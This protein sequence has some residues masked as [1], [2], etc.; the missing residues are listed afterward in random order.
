MVCLLVAIPTCPRPA[1]SPT[2][3]LLRLLIPAFSPLPVIALGSLPLL[4]SFRGP[5][6]CPPSNVVHLVLLLEWELSFH[7]F[8]HVV[9]FDTFLKICTRFVLEFNVFSLQSS[10]SVIM[11]QN[12]INVNSWTMVFSS[13]AGSFSLSNLLAVSATR[14]PSSASRFMNF[15]F[16]LNVG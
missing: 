1:S 15:T 6:R 3:H 14:S 8:G 7:P 4:A 2:Y 5:L 12:F 9:H 11:A 10:Q 16:L 13:S